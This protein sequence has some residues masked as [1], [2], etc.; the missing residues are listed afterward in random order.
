MII[1]VETR[2]TLNCCLRCTLLYHPYSDGFFLLLFW[3]CIVYYMHAEQDGLLTTTGKVF[4]SSHRISSFLIV[5]YWLLALSHFYQNFSSIVHCVACSNFCF[6]RNIWNASIAVEM[7]LIKMFSMKCMLCSI[8]NSK[9]ST[10][11]VP[12]NSFI[13]LIPTILLFARSCLV[14]KCLRAFIFKPKNAISSPFQW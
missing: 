2:R 5:V 12:I 7:V 4:I 8:D 1:H 13:D 3:V 14:C 11:S 9:V 6:L 10:G